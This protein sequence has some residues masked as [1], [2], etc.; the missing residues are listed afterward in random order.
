M[1]SGSLAPLRHRNFRWYYIAS[2]IDVAGSM[3]AGVAFAFAVL[4]VENSPSALGYV[5][6]ANTVPMVLFMLYGGV[7]AD[8]LPL[9]LV[10]RFGL[11]VAG[12]LQGLTAALVITGAAHIWM[13]IVLAA[14][15]GTVMALVF[16]AL[17]SIMPQLV[18]REL[19]QQANALQSLSRGSMRI[20]GP[21]VAALLVAGV[22]PGWALGVDAAT[23]LVAAGVLL[24]VRLPPRP[25]R[26]GQTST[27]DELREG[28]TYFR[29][30]TW[31]WV[32]VLGF[33]L[34]NAIHTGAWFTLG[35]PRAKETI[36]VKGWGYVLSAESVGLILVT[37]VLLRVS[38]RRPLLTGMLGVTL[39][40]LPILVFGAVP[41]VVPLL[42]VALLAGAGS[43]V[44]NIGW[45]V[46]MQE[47][48]PERMLSRAFSYDALGSFVAMPV[49]QLLAGPLAA[50]FGY[51]DVMVVS[52]LLYFV[53]CVL[54]L[55]SRSVR[56]L[57][58]V[59]AP[60]PG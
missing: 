39:M 57:R 38:L 44:F 52:G 51:R 8:R 11:L 41:H 6:A 18:P 17:V 4:A 60:A 43:E 34:L 28:W 13:L 49:G 42:C 5:L 30:T 35:P 26:E 33:A 40:G 24:A 25:P 47:H 9:T 1:D 12:L 32:V 3:M 50:A 21:T 14:L 7:V 23:Y 48:V 54:V 2:T 37:L 10:L 31:L 55:S 58:R 16:P 46:S 56:N 22:G 45:T 27:I 53:I 19:L 15:S 59:P 36:G 29:S 20:I